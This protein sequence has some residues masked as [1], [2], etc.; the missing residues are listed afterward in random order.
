MHLSI[1]SPG[2]ILLGKSVSR[3]AK[4]S[5]INVP[6]IVTLDKS[7]LTECVGSVPARVLRGVV[8]GMRLVLELE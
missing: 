6:Q 3:L 5:V 2:N 7:F 4:P 1:T 8:A